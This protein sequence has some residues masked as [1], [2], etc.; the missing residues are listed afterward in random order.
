MPK[1]QR[2]RT[3]LDWRDPDYEPA[4]DQSD[5]AEVD[6]DDYLTDHELDHA[7]SAAETHWKEAP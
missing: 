1:A 2:W 4:P 6:Y 5:D 7:A 3:L